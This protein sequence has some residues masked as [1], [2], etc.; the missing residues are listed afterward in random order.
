MGHRERQTDKQTEK[1]RQTDSQTY[2]IKIHIYRQKYRR[3]VYLIAG[4]LSSTQ[5]FVLMALW[6]GQ[7]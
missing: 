6:Q 4:G 3:T 7:L 5:S 2:N 1:D